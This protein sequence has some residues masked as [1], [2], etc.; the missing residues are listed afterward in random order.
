MVDI[1]DTPNPTR[2][3]HVNAALSVLWARQDYD[4][5]EPSSA[6]IVDAI[7]TLGLHCDGIDRIDVLLDS[8]DIIADAVRRDFAYK[9]EIAMRDPE[10]EG[11]ENPDKVARQLEAIVGE[12]RPICAQRAAAID[13]LQAAL[14]A[15][16]RLGK[17]TYG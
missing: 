5:D 8:V 6:E 7:H 10:D 13:Q 9:P 1:N 2:P 16:A 17:V 11:R 12:V 15:I 3:D 14:E 4:A